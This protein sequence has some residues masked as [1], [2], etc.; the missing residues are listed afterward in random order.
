MFVFYQNDNKIFLLVEADEETVITDGSDNADGQLTTAVTMT[1]M[2]TA[3]KTAL[4]RRNWTDQRHP[5]LMTSS[6][7]PLSDKGRE[8]SV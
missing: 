1:I 6:P 7:L 4:I 8:F 5:G 3:V 2:A